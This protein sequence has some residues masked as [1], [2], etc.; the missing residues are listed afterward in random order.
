[1]YLTFDEMAAS[2][3]L[4]HYYVVTDKINTHSYCRPRSVKMTRFARAFR[5]GGTPLHFP[6]SLV[7][8]MFLVRKRKWAL[9]FISLL[10][11]RRDWHTLCLQLLLVTLINIVGFTTFNRLLILMPDHMKTTGCA[12][13]H[14]LDYWLYLQ[15]FLSYAQEYL[16]WFQGSYL[17]TDKI[18]PITRFFSYRCHFYDK[19]RTGGNRSRFTDANRIIDAWPVQS[20]R[21]MSI[22]SIIAIVLFHKIASFLFDLLGT[23]LTLHYFLLWSLLKDESHEN[24][25]ANSSL[26]FSIIEDINGIETIKSLISESS[27]IKRTYKFVTYLKV[28]HM[29]VL[30]VCKVFESSVWF[31]L[32]VLIFLWLE[33]HCHGSKSVWDS[34]SL[35]IHF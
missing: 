1:M 23:Q 31:D 3:K 22:V 5:T 24:D 35:I 25:E 18:Y 2:R 26:S 33:L 28:L 4:L 32:N 12:W 19:R 6:G 27:V 21:R 16:L 14:R 30:R 13:F 20:C 34:S 9:D 10:I 11:N 8:L 15:Q 17:S 7:R 29:G